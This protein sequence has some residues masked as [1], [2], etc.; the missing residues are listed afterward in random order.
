[1]HREALDPKKHKNGD[2]KEYASQRDP[3]LLLNH[4][5]L[6]IDTDAEPS[7]LASSH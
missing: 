2:F 4:M 5:V 3:L 7:T 6:I 1:M